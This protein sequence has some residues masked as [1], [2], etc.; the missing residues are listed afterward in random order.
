MSKDDA[1]SITNNWKTNLNEEMNYYEIFL[2]HIK[3]SEET[4]Y[5]R[6]REKNTK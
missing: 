2:L 4:Y 3:L 1:I 5:Q 6:N